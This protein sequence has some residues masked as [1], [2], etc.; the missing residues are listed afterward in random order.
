VDV[1]FHC[2][3]IENEAMLR[4]L[5]NTP[6]TAEKIPISLA[7]EIGEFIYSKLKVSRLPV[8]QSSGVILDVPYTKAINFGRVFLYLSYED[9]I[10]INRYLH[11]LFYIMFLQFVSVGRTNNQPTKD[12]LNTFITLVKL[13][14]QPTFYDKLKKYEYR[15][16]VKTL[17]L[18]NSVNLITDR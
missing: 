4:L 17:I 3:K 8:K 12:I 18:Y 11:S 10:Q 6:K 1:K 2:A 14:D 5:T 7:T 16:R 9:H 13:H 15:N